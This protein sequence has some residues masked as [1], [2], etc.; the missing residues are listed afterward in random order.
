MSWIDQV[1]KKR[2]LEQQARQLIQTDAFKEVRD[3]FYRK[4]C[5]QAYK[6]SILLCCDFLFRQ[7]NYKKNGLTKFIKFFATHCDDAS[8]DGIFFK[9]LNK[10]MAIETGIDIQKLFDDIWESDNDELQKSN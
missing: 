4:A 9:E 7:H 8:R 1:H 10:A 5:K 2:K 6:S 3:D